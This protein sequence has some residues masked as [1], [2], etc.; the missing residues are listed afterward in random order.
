MNRP[1]Y[2]EL[3]ATDIAASRDFYTRAFGW[4]LTAF[5]PTY[6]ATTTGDV[7][8][9]LQGD[10]SHA[11]VAP[12]L[13]IQVADLGVALAAVVAA[14]GAITLPIFA[15]PGGHRFHF[16]DPGGN[17]LAAYKPD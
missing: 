12:L 8:V 13:I 17:E 4:T 3:G 16:R 5:G 14:G 15:Y 2:I 6:A 11:P 9:G 7:D 1:N 10:P